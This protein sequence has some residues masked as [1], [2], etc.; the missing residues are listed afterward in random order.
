MQIFNSITKQKQEFTPLIPGK[1]GLYVC[2][3][4]V[5]D[6][7]HIGHARTAVSFDIITRYWRYRGFEVN[8]VRNITDVDDKIINRAQENDE[9][10]DSLTERMI[11]SGEEDYAKLGILPPDNEPR[12]TM[13]MAEMIAMIEALI[14]KGFAYVGGNGDVFYDVRKFDNYGALSHKNIDELQVGARMAIDEAKNNPLD[15]VLWKMAKPNEPSWDSPWGKGRPGWHIECSA[16]STTCLGENFDIHGG[17]MDLKFPHH[18]NEIAQSEAAT[19]KTFANLWIHSGLVTINREKMSKSLGNFFTIKE[20]LEKYKAE[21][22]RYF[23]MSSHYRSP[24]NYSQE[25]LEIAEGALVR[26]Y[27]TLRGLQSGLAPENSEYETRFQIAMDDDFNTPEALAVMFDITHKINRVRETEPEHA[28]NLG[29]LLSKL[30]GVFGLLDQ[31]PEAFLQAPAAEDAISADAIE[32]LIAER[33][34]ARADKNWARADEIRD[35]LIAHGVALEDGAKGT[36]WR[37][38][39]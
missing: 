10:I 24:V 31:Q 7:S 5:Y 12:A 21:T 1:I 30:G 17:G 22:V 18:E 36:T 14:N 37:R 11:K 38:E 3:N 25:S 29:A 32:A 13:H 9:D 2:G 26:F 28:A 39:V 35:E 20:V 34:Q 27:T 16:M 4:T 23:L 6:H 8:Y 33:N 19:G 15:F